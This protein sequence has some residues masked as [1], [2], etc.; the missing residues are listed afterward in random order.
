[1]MF[2]TTSFSL[3]LHACVQSTSYGNFLLLQLYNYVTFFSYEYTHRLHFV[4]HQ[5]AT[6]YHISA[7]YIPLTQRFFFCAMHSF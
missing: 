3:F 6:P 4:W 7:T 2:S 1:M 5:A